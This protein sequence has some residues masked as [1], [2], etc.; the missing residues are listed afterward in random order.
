MGR[1]KVA[2]AELNVR[3]QRRSKPV[4]GERKIFLLLLRAHGHDLVGEVA[5]EKIG[6]T[7]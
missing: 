2:A 4:E 3:R 1:D 5:K 7:N 6:A